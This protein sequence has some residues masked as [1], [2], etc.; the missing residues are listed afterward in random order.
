[1]LN[2]HQIFKICK[3]SVFLQEQENYVFLEVV[4]AN[5]FG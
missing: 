1:M 2:F 3:N 4:Q 5:S